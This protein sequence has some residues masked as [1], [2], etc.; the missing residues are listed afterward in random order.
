MIPAETRYETHDGELLAIVE[1]FKTWRH[2]LE[3]SR[4]EVLVLTDH[5]NLRRFM[6]TKSLSSRQVRWAQELSCY[7]FR[8]DY[9]QGKA[10]R[11]ADALFQY[12]QRSAKEEDTLQAENVKIL[13]RLQSLLAKVSGFLANSS[14]LSPLYQVLICGTHVFPQLNQFWDSL[15]SDIAHDGPYASIKDM[16]LQ[17]PELQ[18]NDKKA[19]VLRAAG[20]PEG[21]K[22]VKGVLQYRGLPY[23]PEIIRFEMISHHYNDPLVGHFGIDKIRKLVGRKY[24]WPSLRKNIKNY[25]SGCDVCLASKVVCHKPYRDLESLLIPTHRWKDLSMDFVIGLPL[26][27]D[28]KGDNY[29]SI[30]VIVDRLTKIVHYEPVKVTIDAPGLAKV[31]IDVVVRHHGLPD[32]IISD[33]GAIFTSKFWSSLCYFLGIK[34]R[35]STVFHPQTDGQTERQNSTMEAYLRAFVNWEQNDWARLLPMAEFAY[36]NSK[37]ASIGHTPFKLNCDYHPR[38]LY[39]KKVDPRS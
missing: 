26:F 18:D 20:L 15:Q 35:L 29:D 34:R 21:W 5:N 12:P 7:H 38:M 6:D 8:I 14:H 2:Y 24:Y 1:A 11:A 3:G 23:F 16:N 17:F 30:L 19:K 27:A 22:K 32:S 9:R 25:V 39:E 37:N 31:I 33:R 4:H 10:N 36:N 13:H 28:W